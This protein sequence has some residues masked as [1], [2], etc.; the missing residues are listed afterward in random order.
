M[1]RVSPWVPNCVVY[2][3][4]SSPAAP[5]G[6]CSNLSCYYC[7]FCF[8]HTG[9]HQ[10]WCVQLVV[11]GVCVGSF[12]FF[13][14]LGS[15]SIPEEIYCR[16]AL[17]AIYISEKFLLASWF[18][19]SPVELNQKFAA[20]AWS[21]RCLLNRSWVLLVLFVCRTCWRKGSYCKKYTKI[22]R[23]FFPIFF[24]F[25]NMQKHIL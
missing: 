18:Y 17:A 13:F 24:M 1:F 15:T 25:Y 22:P 3:L 14:P 19:F 21:S 4:L 9:T 12:F 16:C 8:T 6:S 2:Y 5:W 20:K 7:P 23:T 11:W 10:E